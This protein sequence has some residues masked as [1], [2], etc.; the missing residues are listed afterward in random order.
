MDSLCMSR[1]A[2]VCAGLL[3][4]TFSTPLLEQEGD[5]KRGKVDFQQS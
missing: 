3:V 1:S 4:L 5:A 2:K